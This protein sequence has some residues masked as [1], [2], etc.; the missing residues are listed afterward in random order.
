MY[1]IRT[2]K[3]KYDVD[4]IIDITTDATFK[5]RTSLDWKDCDLPSPGPTVGHYWH[6]GKSIGLDSAD[7]SEIQSII[8]A[9]EAPILAQRE[10]DDPGPLVRP[11][12]SQDA[13]V[14]E[15]A[16]Y[17]GGASKFAED[18]KKRTAIAEA[19]AHPKSVASLRK[20][21]YVDAPQ[22]VI[23]SE[24]NYARLCDQLE[25]AQ[26]M[27]AGFSTTTNYTVTPAPDDLS[28]TTITFNPPLT[29]PDKD[30]ISGENIGI[31]TMNCP[32]QDE[33][34]GDITDF[35][36]YWAELE[37]EIQKDVDKMKS[38]LGL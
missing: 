30:P 10:A 34:D 3:N 2:K 8:E 25:S 5:N 38:D 19:K 4:V 22:Q 18:Q 28:F 20:P 29:F 15:E 31:T 23:A 26:V 13:V 27:N 37:V 9:V 36:T 32:P 1:Y 21:S 7:Y 35:I 12:S 24:A 6:N 17:M 11:D 14:P 33:T 16:P